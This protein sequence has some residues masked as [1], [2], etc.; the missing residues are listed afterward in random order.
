MS[1]AASTSTIELWASWEGHIV[2]EEFPL[3]RC[4]GSTDHSGV[5][6]TE[7]R[8]TASPELAIKI[9]PAVPVQAEATLS[10]WR[11]AAGLDHPN[12]V[13]IFEAGQ[14]QVDGRPYLYCVMEYADQDLAQLLQR[15]ALTEDE[16]RE[17]LIPALGALAFLHD[18]KFVQGRVKP[19]NVLVVGDQLKL[20]SDTISRVGESVTASEASVYDPPEVHEV[21]RSAAG[22]IWAL[23]ITICEALTR[24]QPLGLHGGAGGA[25]LPPEL[26]QTFRELVAW[27]MSRRP[28]DRPEVPELEAALRG[29]RTVPVAIPAVEPGAAEEAQPVAVTQPA[30]TTPVVAPPAVAPPATVPPAVVPPSEPPAPQTIAI[31]PAQSA[32]SIAPSATAAAPSAPKPVAPNVAQRTPAEPP[33]TA[34]PAANAASARTVA[35]ASSTAPATTARPAANAKPA[36]SPP[37]TTAK[38]ARSSE[39]PTNA[40][41][42]A[43]P[44]AK[45]RYA[46]W[47]VSFAAVLAIAWAGVKL[48]S[49]PPDESS[50]EP[51]GDPVADIASEDASTA[52]SSAASADRADGESASRVTPPAAASAAPPRKLSSRPPATTE[53]TLSSDEIQEVVPEVPLSARRTIRGRVRVAV[54]V[55]VEQDGTVFAALAD[56]PGPSRYFERLAVDAAKKWTFAPASSDEQRLMQV[57]FVFTRDGTTASAT[58]LR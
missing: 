30:V 57:R 4:L 54:R 28:S 21:G 23:G 34:A 17:M 9:I 43:V 38:S 44:L 24:R 41:S 37:L 5:F 8:K 7:S 2:N 14:C 18:R 29:E 45:P 3:R 42:P 55:I 47:A 13:R 48:L 33:A 40:T 53:S 39:R 16:A 32:A 27:C 20:A 49:E 52:A 1:A 10:R 12:V 58:A 19:S 46:V 36:S 31:Q 50:A 6:L 25:V 26:S 22:D 56:D 15:R 35:S 11:A 51:A